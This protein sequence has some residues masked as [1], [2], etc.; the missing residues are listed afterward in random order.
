M[1]ASVSQPASRIRFPIPWESPFDSY[2][3]LDALGSFF[4]PWNPIGW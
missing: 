4:C 3:A 2:F 1:L